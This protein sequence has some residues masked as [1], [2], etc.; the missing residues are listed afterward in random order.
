MWHHV[1]SATL[2]SYP[3]PLNVM[4]REKHDRWWH[5]LT[6]GSVVPTA[7]LLETA[8][9]VLDLCSDLDATLMQTCQDEDSTAVHAAAVNSTLAAAPAAAVA[10]FQVG[11]S[12]LMQ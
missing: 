3:E 5:R 8:V 7:R 9:P 2:Q 4:A 10:L 1:L 6:A 12:L 11:N